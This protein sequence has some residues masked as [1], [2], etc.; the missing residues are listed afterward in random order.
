MPLQQPGDIIAG[1]Y[2]VLRPLGTG[3]L[4]E[5][6]LCHDSQTGQQVAVK[7]L[8][9]DKEIPPSVI[10]QTQREARILS[11]FSHRNII[12]IFDFALDSRGYYFVLEFVDGPSLAEIIRQTPL[13]QHTFL[14]FATQC[15]EGLGAAHRKN[16]LHLD[17]KPANLMLHNFPG[18]NFI[19]KILDFGVAKLIEETSHTHENEEMF[20]SIYYISPEQLTQKPLDARTDLYSLGHVFYQ[21]LTGT[22]A[23]PGIDDMIALAKA[24]LYQ[25][26]VSLREIKPELDETL[27]HWIYW[28]MAKKPEDRPA[29][30]QTALFE[31][32][33]IRL[34]LSKASS[35]EEYA[36][37]EEDTTGD[38]RETKPPGKKKLLDRLFNR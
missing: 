9:E 32:T 33:K 30:D 11:E 28:L 27:C 3:G 18:Q 29:T 10:E 1:R 21:T 7:R 2:E 16:L 17:I 35:P 38:V 34:R 26:P 5:V 12:R 19:V 37:P 14:D 8:K 36:I 4:G 25:A 6:Y 23:F 22:T 31:L 24:H 15:L 20:G 13:D